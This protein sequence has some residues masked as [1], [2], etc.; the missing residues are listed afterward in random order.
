MIVQVTF[1]LSKFCA[2]AFADAL[3]SLQD[4]IQRQTKASNSLCSEVGHAY[5]Q[6]QRLPVV[7]NRACEFPS[8]APL[9]VGKPHKHAY[10]SGSRVTGET[11]W[12]PA[13]VT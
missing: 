8:V 13:Q 1:Q 2:A 12:G 9:V 11:N 3:S 6:V 7:T 10:M 5:M 4:E